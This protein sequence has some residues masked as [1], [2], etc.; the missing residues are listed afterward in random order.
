[1]EFLHT[2]TKGG[3]P[4]EEVEA[5][6]GGRHCS[7][8]DTSGRG[9]DGIT[10]ASGGV[11]PAKMESVEKVW[12][13]GTLATAETRRRVDEGDWNTILRVPCEERGLLL[14]AKVGV[15]NASQ[16]GVDTGISGREGVAVAVLST[17]ATARDAADRDPP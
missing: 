2:E 16:T 8:Q 14:R 6:P 15:L 10:E 12:E 17:A 11:E 9:S 5:V 7:Y 13:R 3:G 1:M 4:A